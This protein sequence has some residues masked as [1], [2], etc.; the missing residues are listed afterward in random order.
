MSVFRP[1][2]KKQAKLRLALMGPPGGGK[3]WS[4]LALATELARGGKVAVI[5]TERG[6]SELYADRFTFDVAPL[7]PPFAPVRYADLLRQAGEAGYAVIVIDSLSH[8]WEGEGGVQDIVD[9]AADKAGGN[10]W[11]GWAKGTPEYRRLIDAIYA[12]PAHVIATMRSKIEWAEGTNAQGRKTYERVGTAAV[13]RGGIEYEFSLVGELDQGDHRI[14]ISKSRAGTA[15][16]PEYL[17][18]VPGSIRNVKALAADVIAWLDS[19]AAPAEPLS[20]DGFLTL[21][22]EA[23]FSRE[24]ARTIW[25]AKGVTEDM[26]RHDP[27][28]VRAIVAEYP[29]A[30]PEP[31]TPAEPVQ[32]ADVARA[33]P[34]TVVIGADGLTDVEREALAQ[35]RRTRD[36]QHLA[37]IDA[38]GGDV[39]KDEAKV[40]RAKW[41]REAAAEARRAKRD[42][43]DD[44]KDAEARKGDEGDA[45]PALPATGEEEA[46]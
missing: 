28:R 26:L 25:R 14:T 10:K 24:Q 34:G 22:E 35:A 19:G 43:D 3:T 27:D 41:R 29:R 8:G 17:A 40:L 38:E 36:E 11:A 1:A 31:E 42:P 30:V 4:A 21:C 6:S 5:D 33:F 12:S 46:A 15:V 9:K 39:A 13:Q 18:G 32:P 23:G 2:E 45:Q 20:A 44:E 16:K 37:V 7:F